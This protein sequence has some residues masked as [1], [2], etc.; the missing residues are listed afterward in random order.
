LRGLHPL[1]AVGA[2]E[3]RPGG[4][5]NKERIVPRLSSFAYVSRV[6]VLGCLLLPPAAGCRDDLTAPRSPDTDT[7]PLP[8]GGDARPPDSAGVEGGAGDATASDT[9]PGAPDATPADAVT[10]GDAPP[11]SADLAPDLPPP[12]PDMPPPPDAPPVGP[13]CGTQRPDISGVTNTDGLAIGTDG[14]IYYTQAGTPTGWVGR[15]RPGAPPEPRWVA[16]PGGGQL[17]GLAVDGARQRL[18]VSSAV[19]HMIHQVALDSPQSVLRQFTRDVHEPDDLAVG[20]GGDVYF[21]DSDTKIY[22]VSPAGELETA[23]PQAF[24]APTTAVAFAR[25]GAAFGD[26]FVGTS[27]TSS[28]IFRI[29]ITAGVERS[30]AP[31]GDYRG[32]VQG[33]AFDQ[34]GRLYLTRPGVQG[35]ELFRVDAD[36]KNLVQVA[37]G[38]NLRSLAFG[39]GV[40]DCRDL[41]VASLSGPLLRVTVDVPGAMVP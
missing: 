34:Q 23:T 12:P 15:L 13:G 6:A 35:A 22:R 7:T 14:T 11:A 24:A 31:F 21:P 20:P 17:R 25:S 39:R 27:N 32:A 41:Y 9:A 3:I 36:G 28:A 10:P 16:V 8:D 19:G 5:A 18:Y 1:R 37:A 26:L 30:R 29:A 2:P 38:P 33:L 4:D 40:L